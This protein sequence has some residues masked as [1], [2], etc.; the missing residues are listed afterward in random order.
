MAAT[1]IDRKVNVQPNHLPATIV[2]AIVGNDVDGSI[3]V[4]QSENLSAK[5]NINFAGGI[6]KGLRI[7]GD[8][9]TVLGSLVLSANDTVLSVSAAGVHTSSPRLYGPSNPLAGK[10]IPNTGGNLTVCHTGIVDLPS[11]TGEPV[12]YTVQVFVTY[13]GDEKGYN[14]KTSAFIRPV[15]VG[16][17]IVVGEVSGLTI[18]A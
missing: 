3:K 8:P 13:L 15:N 18:A 4:P 10:P 1:A 17:P 14:V 7:E 6:R 5:G 11:T 12:A 2:L 9:A 16:G